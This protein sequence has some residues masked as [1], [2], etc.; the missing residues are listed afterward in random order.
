M[1]NPRPFQVMS[2]PNGPRCNLDCTYCYYLEKERFYPDEKKFRMADDVLETYVRDYIA[3]QVAT[4]APEI[5]FSWQGGEPTLMGL[6]FFRR[7]VAL[8]EKYA[9]AGAVVRNALQTNGTLLDQEWATFLKAHDFLVGLSIDGPRELHDR[10]R[11]D[12]AGRASFDQVMAAVE[13]LK[14]H[15]VAFNA[16]TV[17]NRLNARK[18]REVYRFLKEIGVDFVQFIPIVERSADGATLAGAPQQESTIEAKVTT[19][20][21]LPGDYGT[22]LCRV[23]DEWIKNDVGR[24]FVQFFDVQLGLWAGA[25]ASL[26]WFAETCGQGLALEHNGDLYACDHYVYPQYRLGNI[27][28]TPMDALAASPF[29]DK[30]GADK[31]D[32]LPR[33]CR[34][35]EYRF[36]CNGGCPKHRF[37]KTSG[38]EAGLNY[39]CESYQRF[40]AHAGDDLRAMAALVHRGRPAADIMQLRSRHA[41]ADAHTPGRNDPCPCGSGKKLKHCCRDAETAMRKRASIARP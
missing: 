16:L 36:A 35:C 31:R 1:P 12:R 28:H 11:I 29:Q 8:Q 18:P 27:M 25:P 33:Q 7:A 13:L 5:W 38:G 14:T 2:K 20:S 4:G 39:F 17:V 22:F 15:G 9:P 23:F 37:L 3:A 30:F 34:A 41:A 32:T 24:I 21:V 6:D 10:Y 40:F 19:W 26:C